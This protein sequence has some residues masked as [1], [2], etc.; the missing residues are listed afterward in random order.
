MK[1]GI[2]SVIGRSTATEKG[3]ACRGNSVRGSL[4][5]REQEGFQD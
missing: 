2:D 4:A 1:C 3:E 5:E